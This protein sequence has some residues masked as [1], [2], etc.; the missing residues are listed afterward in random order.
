MTLEEARD[1]ARAALRIKNTQE[2]WSIT[3]Q[4][5][6]AAPRDPDTLLLAAETEASLGHLAVARLLVNCALAVAPQFAAA[7]DFRGRLA[8]FDCRA[9]AG[10]Y[11]SG[12][13]ALR[14]RHMDYPANI[15]LETVGRC[16]AHCGFCP[17]DQLERAS[18]EMSDALYEKIIREVSA[19]PPGIP[20][21]VFLNVVNEPFMDKKIFERIALLNLAIPRATLGLYT[22]LNV[23]P[24]GFFEKFRNVRRLTYFNVSF[25]AANEPEYRESMR[26]DFQR[27][28]SHI[29]KLLDANRSHSDV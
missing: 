9:A 23:L 28:V 15:Q 17:H 2:A 1:Y 10:Q 8:T 16:N 21:N 5:L 25:N 27:T 19:I 20:V 4:V 13:L 14:A 24:P 18:E 3:H 11:V 26:L 22:N 29:R 12:Y 7:L 6:Y